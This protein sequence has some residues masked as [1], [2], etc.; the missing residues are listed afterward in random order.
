MDMP[1]PRFLIAALAA[2]ALALPVIVPV[3]AAAQSFAPRIR[4]DEQVITAYELDQRQRFLTILGVQGDLAREAETTLIDDRLRVAE[5]RRVG[6][7]ATPEQVRAG[8]EEFA[9]RAEL[10]A[11]ELIDIFAQNGIAEATFRDFVEAGVVWRDLVRARFVPRLQNVSEA[12]IDRALL[13][14]SQR[15]PTVRVQFSELLLP[16]GRNAEAL[17]LSQSL[18][19]EAAFAAAARERSLAATAAEGGRVDWTPVAWLPPQVAAAL[20]SVQA[21]QV[22]PPV[23]VAGGVAIYLLRG[24]QTLPSVTPRVTLVEYATVAIPGAGTPQAAAEVAR[25]RAGADRCGDIWGLT[26]GGAD[27][28]R[29]ERRLLSDTP[30][31]I[32]AELG[33]LDIGEASARLTSG[34][35]VL[36]LMLCER[37]VES[38]QAPSREAIRERIILERLEGSARIWLAELRARADIRR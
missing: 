31:A 21:G 35:A 32:A 26:Q 23:A 22:T 6:L 25:L 8:M 4:V 12:D 7:R 20:G 36:F 19:G 30:A 15:G 2:L 9:A 11:E 13:M 34:G 33:R 16:A 29:V 28:V 1:M 37:R 14:E 38:G 18:R 27:R 10:T 5:A 3:P 17:R 24:T